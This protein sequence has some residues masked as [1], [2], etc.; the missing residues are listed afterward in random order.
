MF[1]E[2]TALA[3]KATPETANVVRLQVDARKFAVARLAPRK[4]GDHIS[5]NIKG[6][7]N[8]QPQIL[9]Q[10]S[11]DEGAVAIGEQ[12]KLPE[13]LYAYGMKQASNF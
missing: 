8:F 7:I 13:S 5:H 9:I 2:I 3:D 6:G 11:S 1:D 10:C 12:K 4:Y